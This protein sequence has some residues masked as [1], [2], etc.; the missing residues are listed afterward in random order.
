MPLPSAAQVLDLWDGWENA[1]LPDRALAILAT[2]DPQGDPASLTVAERDRSLIHLRRDILGS[3]MEMVVT[4]PRC[5]VDVSFAVEADDLVAS[6]D[7]GDVDPVIRSSTGDWHFS[8]RLPTTQIMC[9][10]AAAGEPAAGRRILLDRCLVEV[11]HGDVRLDPREVQADGEA[12]FAAVLEDEFPGGETAFAVSCG[13]CG[14]EWEAEFDI[15]SYLWTEL[16][17]LA[18]RIITDVHQLAAAYGWR[19]SE[20]VAMSARRRSAYIEMLP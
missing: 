1:N 19:E 9:E 6:L 20:I 14:H 13:E 16:V 3:T 15:T 11:S 8:Y 17:Q 7:A 2:V 4:C 12:A 5:E 18:R 10:V